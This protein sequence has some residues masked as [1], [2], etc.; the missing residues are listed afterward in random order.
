MEFITKLRGMTA[1][2]VLGAMIEGLENPAT[3]VFMADFGSIDKD[4]PKICYGCAATNTICYI[5]GAKGLDFCQE[6]ELAAYEEAGIH[7]YKCV[8]ADYFDIS[9]FED[10]IDALRK[11][12]VAK[13]NDKMLD[14]NMDHLRLPIPD[15]YLPFLDDNN[16]KKHLQ[17]YKD[18]YESI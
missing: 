13:Y 7:K 6:R 2:Q 1:K 12:S 17:P 5:T 10:A 4:N 18:F 3:T 14:L 9:V 11:G 8:G 16:Y 15:K